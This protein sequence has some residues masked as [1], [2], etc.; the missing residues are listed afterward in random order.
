MRGCVD[1]AI[2]ATKSSIVKCKKSCSVLDCR[3][4]L[5]NQY[6]GALGYKGRIIQ[7]AGRAPCL[8]VLFAL[9]AVVF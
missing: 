3:Q 2:E 8:E 4:A 7:T 9:P 5:P 1:V 6:K